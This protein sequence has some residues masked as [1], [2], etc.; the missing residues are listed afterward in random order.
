MTNYDLLRPISKDMKV[1]SRFQFDDAVKFESY[2]IRLSNQTK[3]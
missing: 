3:N 1:C 2:W